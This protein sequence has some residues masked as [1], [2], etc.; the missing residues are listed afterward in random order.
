MTDLKSCDIGM[1]GLGVIGRNLLLNIAGRGFSAAAYNRHPEKLRTLMNEAKGLPVTGAADLKGFAALLRSPRA[2]IIMVPAG[3]AVDEVVGSLVPFL[4]KGDL[5]IDAG[6]S[7]YKD[8][9]RRAE[10]LAAKGLLFTG[11]GVSGGEEGA[12]RGPSIMAG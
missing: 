10:N 4:D 1:V 7:Y 11:R 6:N 8:T 5:I 3:A 2:I 12:R 9:E